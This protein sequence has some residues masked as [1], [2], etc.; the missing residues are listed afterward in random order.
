MKNALVL[1]KVS[2]TYKNSDFKLDEVSF[3]V[4]QGTILGFVGKNASGKTTTIQS[5]LGVIK[6]DSGKIEMLGHD[7]NENLFA[8][9]ND[10]GVVFDTI[11]FPTEMTAKHIENILRDTYKNWDSEVFNHY[12][13]KFGIDT[14]KK[15][16]TF[17]RG[18]TMK[19]ALAVALSHGAKLLI[20]DEATAGLDPVAREEILDILLDFVSNEE[21]SILLS[22]HISSDLEKI[23]DYI[24]FIADGKLILSEEKDV[25]LYEYGVAKMKMA[26]FEKLSQDEFLSH[27]KRGLQ[28]EVLV[29]NKVEFIKKYPNI[30]V[31]NATIDEILALITKQ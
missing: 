4:P 22:S 28:I 8:L 15:I 20:L 16:K 1:E 23:A 17:S 2:K 27:R 13:K 6:P 19:F 10:V 3:C 5:I 30:V 12:L 26:D 31:D 11:S 25:L 24:T 29:N 7:I 14:K 9:K 18:M 21:N